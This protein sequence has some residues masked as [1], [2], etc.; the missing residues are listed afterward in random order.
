MDFNG[1]Y[2]QYNQQ[3]Y[4][5]CLGYTNEEAWAKD[6]AQDTFISVWKNLEKFRGDA[7]VRTWIYRIAVNNC[8]KQLGKRRRTRTAEI[9]ERVLEQKEVNPRLL[10]LR[11]YISELPELDRLIISME[12]EELPQAEIA[13]VL[14]LSPGNVRV[15]IHRIKETLSKK[16]KMQN[17]V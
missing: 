16:F 6:I 13:E 7:E 10:L 14:N 15:K 1:I 17:H 2:Q 4:R 12:L 5:L 9:P 11:K 8:I 3:I